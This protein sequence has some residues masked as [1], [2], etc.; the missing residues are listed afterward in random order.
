VTPSEETPPGVWIGEQVTRYGRDRK[1]LNPEVLRALNKVQAQI[2]QNPT[3]G[4]RKRGRLRAVYVEK[5]TAQHD[6]RLG[7]YV[8][9]EKTRT[10]RFLAV[11][12]H[13]NFYRDLS[14]YVGVQPGVVRESAKSSWARTGRGR[15]GSQERRVS[16]RS[17][18]SARLRSRARPAYNTRQ[19][20]DDGEE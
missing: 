11:G 7:A 10:V 2:L 16:R 3:R 17:P 18:A 1:S 6:Q 13:E 12:Q 14:R 9:I 5:F 20:R 8:L 4:D 19:I 15:R